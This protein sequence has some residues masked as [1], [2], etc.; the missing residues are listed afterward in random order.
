MVE[1]L[2]LIMHQ[3]PHMAI[4]V[5]GGSMVQ[6]GRVA[7]LTVRLS[8]SHTE[9]L[10]AHVIDEVL[11]GVDLILGCN[12][13]TRRGAL[14]DFKNSTCRFESE[15]GT[16]VLKGHTEPQGQQLPALSVASIKRAAA[17]PLLTAKQA[18]RL[19][20]RGAQAVLVLVR[21][22]QESG[23]TGSVCPPAPVVSPPQ[24]HT[25]PMKT[26]VLGAVFGAAEG[27]VMPETEQRLASLLERYADV[28]A[29]LKELPPD[30]RVHHSIPL[31]PGAR[32]AFRK[33]Y[34]LSILEEKA[35]AEAVQDMLSRNWLEPS[36]SPYGA[37]VMFV[38][39]P[40]GSLRMVVDY[41][42]LNKHTIRDRFPLPRVDDLLDKMHGKAW[43][44]KMDLQAGYY[45][46]RLAEADKEKTAFNTPSG[47]YQFKV[48]PMG[49]ANAPA[50]FQRVMNSAF[51]DMLGKHLL[52]Y[53]DDLLVMSKTQDQ[54]L[55]HL[56]AV[57]ARLR[58]HKLH[59]KLKKCEFMQREL[60]FLGHIVS[61]AGVRADPAKVEAVRKWPRPKNLKEL[62][63]FLGTANY[64]R[65]HVLGFSILAGPLTDLTKGKAGCSRQS[66]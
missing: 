17:L 42:L 65:K 23:G 4:E 14:F 6:S 56:E 18:E 52:I 36:V 53:M 37:P 41:R 32:P 9:V 58:E 48:L 55:Q 40:D 66:L 44:S 30:R 13:L 20:K 39:K 11:E 26:P 21:K 15:R 2:G 64:V 28:F 46:I 29:E 33:Q 1:R 54:H 3:A 31:E 12:W 51:A 62:Q 60:R 43:V 10:D 50:T 63:A 16:V 47:Q 22:R 57:F 27:T 35:L 45:Q 59:L 5:A 38:A 19:I 24:P 25:W 8:H 61:A 34:R 7:T 49:L